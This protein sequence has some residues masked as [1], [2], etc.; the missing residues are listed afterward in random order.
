MTYVTLHNIFNYKIF[1]DNNHIEKFFH[2]K[3]DD[4]QIVIDISVNL[5]ISRNS[6]LHAEKYF[7]N[8]VNSNQIG[9]VITL[10]R[11]I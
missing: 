8:L 6:Q 10:F 9:I 4:L 3:K 5:Y 11:Q 7:R 1:S 2:S